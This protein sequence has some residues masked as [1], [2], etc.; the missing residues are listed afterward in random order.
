M[1]V[2]ALV[3]RAGPV[4]GGSPGV[5]GM[6]VTGLDTLAFPEATDSSA[7]AAILAAKVALPSTTAGIGLETSISTPSCGWESVGGSEVTCRAISL[8]SPPAQE[9]RSLPGQDHHLGG[10]V[11]DEP[12][13][14]VPWPL[15]GRSAYGIAPP[16][17]TVGDDRNRP[18]DAVFDGHGFA[19]MVKS[20]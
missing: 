9:V 10:P 20:G 11:S 15:T 19:P 13:V 2:V 7:L 5:G 8:R 12:P 1:G 4:V 17:T 16:G 6:D 14:G 18:E 3:N